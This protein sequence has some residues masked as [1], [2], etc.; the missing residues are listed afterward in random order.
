MMRITLSDSPEDLLKTGPT[1]ETILSVDAAP[2]SG[3]PDGRQYLSLT[4]LV[5]TGAS[6]N[7]I[8]EEL[9]RGLGLRIIDFMPVSGIDGE[10]ERPLFLANIYVPRLEHAIF[11]LFTG[12]RLIDEREPDKSPYQVLLGRE[13]LQNFSMVYTGQTGEVVITPEVVAL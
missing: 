13:F 11:G 2:I 6:G 3:L 4:A 9:A 7:C 5:D 12:V 1:I 10:S 8:D